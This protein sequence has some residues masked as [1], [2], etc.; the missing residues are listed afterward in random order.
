MQSSLTEI[1]GCKLLILGKM[2]RASRVKGRTDIHVR[3]DYTG[4]AKG[5]LDGNKKWLLLGYKKLRNSV[6]L[7]V[8]HRP[9]GNFVRLGQIIV[10]KG[11][12]VW[13]HQDTKLQEI[14]LV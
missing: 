10:A 13:E 4:L 2:I 12:K 6:G 3:M 5:E 7:V 1:H 8:Q 11:S 14:A 9:D